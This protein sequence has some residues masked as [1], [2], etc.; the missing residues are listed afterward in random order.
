MTSDKSLFTPS[1]I[2]YSI[3]DWSTIL[4]FPI[5]LSSISEWIV[6]LFFPIASSFISEC[7]ATLFFSTAS[8]S[9][10]EW[11][12]P[13]FLLIADNRGIVACLFWRWLMTFLL[14]EL[15]TRSSSLLLNILDNS[16]IFSCNSSPHPNVCFNIHSWSIVRIFSFLS[17][18]FLAQ[19]LPIRT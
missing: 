7:L 5:S 10:L 4:F 12:V 3:L 17:A 14:S 13:L 8:V 11:L 18:R 16:T 2:S 9:I 15:S 19:V 1:S 6:T